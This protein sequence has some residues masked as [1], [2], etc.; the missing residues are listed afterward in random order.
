[1]KKLVLIFFWFLYFFDGSAQ[2]FI[3]NK[4]HI[5]IYISKDGYFDVVENYDLTFEVQKHGIYRDIQTE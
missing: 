5:Q 2:D 1:M 4:S 3:V